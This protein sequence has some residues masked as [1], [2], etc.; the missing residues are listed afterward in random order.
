MLQALRDHKNLQA[1]ACAFVIA[2]TYDNDR[3]KVALGQELEVC[4]DIIAAIHNHPESEDVQEHACGALQNLAVSKQVILGQGLEVGTE[5]IIAMGN[6]PESKYVQGYACFALVAIALNT[7]NK[8]ILGQELEV[9]KDIVAAMH[10]GNEVVQGFA[11]AAL[12]N[13]ADN[14]DRNQLILGQE[15]EVG[16]EIVAPM[17]NHFES[18]DVQKRACGAL[19]NLAFSNQVT[20]GQEL[21]VCK[22]IVVAMRN[23]PESASDRN[24]VILGQELEVGKE[25]VAAM[26]NHPWIENVQENACGT[27]WNLAASNIR[28]QV[29]LRQELEVGKDIVAAMRNHLRNENLQEIARKALAFFATDTSVEMYLREQNVRNISMTRLKQKMN[30]NETLNARLLVLERLSSRTANGK[31]FKDLFRTTGNS[32]TAYL[33]VETLDLAP[34]ALAHESAAAENLH[35]LAS[36]ILKGLG[37]L[38]F[39]KSTLRSKTC[40]RDAAGKSVGNAFKMV[41][42]GLNLARHFSKLETN[43]LGVDELLAKSL[44][45]HRLVKGL[46]IALA[47]AHAGA[48]G[49]DKAFVVKVHRKVSEALAL[50]ANEVFHGHLDVVERDL[51]SVV[52]VVE[53]GLHLAD[54]DA[55]HALLQKQARETAG[56]VTSSAHEAGPVVGNERARDPLLLAIDNVVIALASGCRANVGHIRASPGLRDHERDVL[57]ACHDVAEHFLLNVVRSELDDGRQRHRVDGKLTQDAAATRTR[58]LLPENQLVKGVKVLRGG[59]APLA[60]V[61]NARDAGLVRLLVQLERVQLALIDPLVDEGNDLLV[62]ELA[63]LV[64]ELHVRVLVVRRR[65][66]L[67]PVRLRKRELVAIRRER[68]LALLHPPSS[69]DFDFDSDSCASVRCLGSRVC[70]SRFVSARCGSA[71]APALAPALL[72]LLLPVPQRVHHVRH[73]L[74]ARSDRRS[75]YVQEPSGTLSPPPCLAQRRRTLRNEGRRQREHK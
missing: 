37:G 23:H 41:L 9:G 42:Q 14:N 2:A 47:S 49:N 63:D 22:E 75:P 52:S 32:S 20:L 26:R 43:D 44:A 45:R 17:R 48:G 6:H 31:V 54:L 28:N 7:R 62:N 12:W 1:A 8:V 29:V 50:L 38:N 65:E 16:K 69:F 70:S 59:A 72:L 34:A 10:P 25:I 36:T 67:A 4:K 39:E 33:A 71:P 53:L 19:Q 40:V 46:L 15:L 73:Y 61:Q 24:Q 66:P 60:R 51:A 21:E 58:E 27:L 5:I 3:N 55:R 30:H 13:L 64:P 57:L 11:C 56:A 68:L 74:R 35:S 18:E